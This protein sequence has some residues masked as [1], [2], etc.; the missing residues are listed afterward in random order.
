MGGT[1]AST[2]AGS[3][4]P[5]PGFPSKPGWLV[6]EFR[7][8]YFGSCRAGVSALL[9]ASKERRKECEARLLD[10]MEGVLG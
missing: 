6:D 3:R 4:I 7:R 5:V 8:T 2:G 1:Q 9:D 10:S